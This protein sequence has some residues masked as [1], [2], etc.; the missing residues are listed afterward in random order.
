MLDPQMRMRADAIQDELLELTRQRPQYDRPDEREHGRLR[1]ILR[2]LVQPPAHPAHTTGG[3]S[4]VPDVTV[5]PALAADRSELARLAALSER[6]IP[7]GLVLIAEV[8][9]VVVAALPVSGGPLL[10]DLWTPSEDVA[11]LLELRSEQVRAADAR[12]AA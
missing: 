2:S 12:R 10:R 4:D 8:D 11:Q 6:R 3:G 1:R 5:R 9:E 7:S